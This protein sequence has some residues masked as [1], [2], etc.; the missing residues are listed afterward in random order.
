[1][2]RVQ[3]TLD[4]SNR[5]QKRPAAMMTSAA[6][7]I[8]PPPMRAAA[9]IM[10]DTR[11]ACHIACGSRIKRLRLYDEATKCGRRTIIGI[12]KKEEESVCMVSWR[13]CAG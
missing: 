12:V 13:E 3:V 2:N 6:E 4:E 8:T 10:G 7:R 5:D 11:R 1:M 9:I